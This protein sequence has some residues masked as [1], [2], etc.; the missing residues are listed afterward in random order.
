[1]PTP[2]WSRYPHVADEPE[3][4]SWLMLIDNLGRS[5]ATVDA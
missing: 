1:M 2:A 3:G 5:P 4:R